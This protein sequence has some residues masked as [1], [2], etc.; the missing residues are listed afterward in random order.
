[1]PFVCPVCQAKCAG[2]SC[3]ACDRRRAAP[4]TLPVAE[5]DP[6]PP[7]PKRRMPR[8]VLVGWIVG[9]MLLTAIVI[10][11]VIVLTSDRGPSPSD[12]SSLPK[13]SNERLDGFSVDTYGEMLMDREFWRSR[14]GSLALS[15]LGPE[16]LRWFLRGLKSDVEHVQTNSLSG[17][18]AD[19]A[20]KY[21]TAFEPQLLAMLKGKFHESV[22]I[23]LI[24]MK[25]DRGIAAVKVRM[26]DPAVG[27]R[28]KKAWADALKEAGQ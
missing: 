2:D 20:A 6:G 16:A 7:V 19:L 5:F 15:Q 23:K 17:L 11:G 21:K 3:E 24:E 27:T 18:T 26:S 22:G 13:T 8:N 25:S 28:I 9:G 12:E 14:D 1:M 10:C 4:P